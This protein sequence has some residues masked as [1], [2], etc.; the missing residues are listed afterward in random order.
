M[1]ENDDPIELA[2]SVSVQPERDGSPDWREQSGRLGANGDAGVA[3][4]WQAR[5]IYGGIS[6]I[7]IAASTVEAFSIDYD[8]TR[9]GRAHGLWEPVVWEASSAIVVIA[10]LGFCRRASRLTAVLRTQPIRTG[11]AFAALACAFSALH[12]IGM[13]LLRE[14]VYGALGATYTFGLSIS[15]ILYEFRKDL[16]SF[17]TLSIL[18]GLAERAFARRDSVAAATAIT[19][20][21][22]VNPS[23]AFASSSR[24]NE[25]WLR[26]G[27]SS[28]LID[29][30][31]IIW[32][33]S[34]GNYVEYA[35]AAGPRHLIRGTLQQEEARLS[36]F[37]I[38]RVHRTRLINL[39]RIV[40]INW[41]KSGDFEVSLDTGETIVGSR[42]HKDQI[43][44]IS[45]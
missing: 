33:G 14:L 27:R 21:N 45:G 42:R 37:G 4:R 18:F 39:Q 20:A 36:A 25:I 28:V 16:F 2:R 29:T 6:L 34:A 38:A 35:M 1:P 12:I 30:R 7:V 13:V 5:T 3:N 22:P 23:A 10:L 24:D 43:A 31:D 26:D 9:L 41:R 44:A 8:L 19:A 15:N 40:A 11:L 32:V 17:S